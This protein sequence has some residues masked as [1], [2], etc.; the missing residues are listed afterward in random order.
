MPQAGRPWLLFLMWCTMAL[1]FMLAPMIFGRCPSLSVHDNDYATNLFRMQRER[2]ERESER[3]T[4]KRL[5]GEAYSIL[6]TAIPLPQRLSWYW[7]KIVSLRMLIIFKLSDLSDHCATEIHRPKSTFRPI[8]SLTEI[9]SGKYFSDVE[10]ARLTSS[11]PFVSLLSRKVG[12]L[13]VSQ[14]N[15]PPRPVTGIALLLLL[16]Y[17]NL[18][19]RYLVLDENTF[20]VPPRTTDKT[21]YSYAVCMHVCMYM[22]A[23]VWAS[24]TPERLN[25]FR[26]YSTFNNLSNTYWCPVIMNILFP[27]K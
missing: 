6:T 15:G 26:S 20:I 18:K 27:G 14:P 13:D 16:F 23:C 2:R 17:F 4:S 3:T 25:R 12:S 19:I 24:Q 9:S 11:P 7:G 22:R 1:G 5:V 8:L 21:G 10:L